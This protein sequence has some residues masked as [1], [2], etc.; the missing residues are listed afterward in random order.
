MNILKTVD[1]K[2]AGEK[3]QGKVRDYYV[4]GPSR[5]L[6]T[7]DRIS[8]FDSVLG[9]IPFKGQVLNQLSA[10]WFTET[11]DIVRNHMLSVPDP[12]VMVVSN[13]TALPIEIVVRGYITG[14]T[15]TAIW[16]SYDMGERNIYG[17]D[18]P[19]GL[20]KN[21]K[22]TRPIITPTTK[23]EIGHDERLTRQ[24]ILSGNLVSK[25]MYEE[26]EE[27]SL[28]L[29]E[30][31]AKRCAERGLIL[32]DTKYEFGVLDGR[33]IL[34]DEIHTP[35]SSRFWIEK[36]YKE[37]FGKGHEPENFDKEFLRLW[38]KD[39]GYTGDG[40]PPKMPISLRDAV[41][42]RYIEA[43]EMITGEAFAFPS[44]KSIGRRIQKNV[45]N[46]LRSV[47]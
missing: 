43:F 3:H 47:S 40:T 26:I 6:I 46:F 25:K 10:F 41:S 14:V 18:F 11:V 38:Y 45:A 42:K 33:L 44:E 15:G 36:S 20:V 13:A 29:Y 35:D 12:N 39:K 17:I 31:G 16:G 30:E 1:L 2:N 8:A 28:A 27:V 24:E 32:V 4:L 7:T 21:Q 22:L 19:D 23:P 5:I 9:H 37:R 34:I